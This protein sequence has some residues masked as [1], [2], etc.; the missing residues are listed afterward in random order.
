MRVF[1]TDEQ[2]LATARRAIADGLDRKLPALQRVYFYM[3]SSTRAE[4]KGE[5]LTNLGGLIVAPPRVFHTVQST[6]RGP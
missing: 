6:P 4:D 2:A 5:I 1:A 3:P